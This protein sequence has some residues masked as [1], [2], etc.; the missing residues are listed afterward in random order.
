MNG[1]MYRFMNFMRGRRGWD[2]FGFFLFLASFAVE[3]LGRIFGSRIVYNIGLFMF[4][5]AMFRVMSRNLVK[6]EE[7]N[8]RYLNISNRIKNWR[9]F[10][11][12]KKN[13]T[14]EYTHSQRSRNGN[15]VTTVYA[16]YYCPVCKQQVRIPSG[17]GRVMIT[18]PRCGEKF[19]VNS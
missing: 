9:Y 8:Q 12:Q 18:C 10:R 1:W 15:F 2:Q 17:K 11:Q 19:P 14:Y 13:G 7:E 16:Y 4:I 6:R 3:I 5:Y